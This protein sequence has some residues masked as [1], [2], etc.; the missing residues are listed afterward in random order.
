MHHS[1]EARANLIPENYNG[2]RKIHPA[3]CDFQNL[4]GLFQNL[5]HENHDWH[6]N[7]QRRCP[8]IQNLGSFSRDHSTQDSRRG[9]EIQDHSHRNPRRYSVFR[10]R[11][12]ALLNSGGDFRRSAQQAGDR[13][14]EFLFTSHPNRNRGSLGDSK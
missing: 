4:T 6:L 8:S 2:S 14:P 9:S 11:C 10:I 5:S 3:G 7:F 1:A 12:S 13:W